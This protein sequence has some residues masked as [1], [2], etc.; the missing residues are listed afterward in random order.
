[1]RNSHLAFEKIKSFEGCRLR[2]YQD[3]AGVWTIGYGHTRD[4]RRGDLITQF[5]AEEYLRMDIAECVAQIETLGLELSLPQLDAL[6]S[7]VF[8]LG[9][10]RLRRSTLLRYIREGRSA[11]AIKKQFRAWVYAGKPPKKLK[12]LVTRRDWEANRFFEEY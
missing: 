9:I 10:G 1:M 8:N 6:V 7:F 2:A 11:D 5:T 4:V 3:A 12:G